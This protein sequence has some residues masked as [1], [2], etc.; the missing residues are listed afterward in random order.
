MGFKSF[1]ELFVVEAFHEYF[2]AIYSLPMLVDP[3]A[4][5]AML[6]LCYAKSLGYLL[7]IMFPSHGILHHNVEFDTRTITTLEKLLGVDL[8]VV[9]SVT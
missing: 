7:R 3:H 6:S 1:I 4:T 9:L 2:G 5:F 8:L